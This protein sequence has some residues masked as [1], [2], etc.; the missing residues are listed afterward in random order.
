ML[1]ANKKLALLTINISIILSRVFFG[2]F[3]FHCAYK[4]VVIQC[5]Q[6]KAHHHSI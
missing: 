6:V 2:A 3:F 4:V 1:L 5:S